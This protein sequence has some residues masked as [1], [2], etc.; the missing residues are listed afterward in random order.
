MNKQ[1][2]TSNERFP[3]STQS[4]SFMQEMI[5]AAAGLARIGG[6]NYILSGCVTTG[7]NV[8]PGVI[9]INGE[10]MPF[11]GGGATS[12]ITII[13][14]LESI[15]ANGL[16]FDNVR[17]KRYAKFATG[18]GENY[19]NWSLF[20]PLQTN[21]QLEKAKATVKYV[22]D[23]ITRIQEKCVPAGMIAMW[24]GAINN[25]PAG[26]Q[27]CDNSLIPGTSRR[28]PD[29]MG[30]FIVGY[31]NDDANYNTIGKT[32]GAKTVSLK[33]AEMPIHSHSFK[34]YYHAE[35]SGYTA[36]GGNLSEILAGEHT[37]SKSTDDDN[38]KF[39]YI[40]STTD[41]SGLGIA[42]ENRPPYYVLAYIIKL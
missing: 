39:F 32:G 6:D 31:N 23:E 30:R 37:G 21:E 8:T 9:V 22:D 38:R 25:L 40:N 1:N 24:S 35:K 29:L 19:I 3:L 36:P 15:F 4:L 11:E 41:S 26:W 28:T 14:T 5:D 42:H 16:T 33:T 27:L 13:E 20:K 7:G 18:T 10:I 2:F 34:N 12:T 17:V